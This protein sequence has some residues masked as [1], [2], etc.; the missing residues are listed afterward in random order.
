[1]IKKNV[2]IA[3]LLLVGLLPACAVVEND[4][5]AWSHITLNKD[6]E[7]N[8]RWQLI[9]SQR[10]G[11]QLDDFRVNLLR[12]GI[13]YN[14][15]GS[16]KNISLWLG[17]DWFTYYGGESLEQENRIWQQILY[18]N[19]CRK[20][21]LTSRTRLEE[22]IFE[23]EDMLTRLRQQLRADYKLTEKFRLIAGGE[24]FVNLNSNERVDEV[25]DQNRMNVGLG[26]DF[27][28]NYSLDM[29]YMLQH[30]NRDIDSLNHTFVTNLILNF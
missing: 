7:N 22:R 3:A 29:L 10:F 11:D 5:Y 18:I 13:G 24:I 6:F 23:H 2:T 8:F 21:R 15:P 14:L 25:L 26:Y 28:K 1:M 16:Y 12:N 27:T 30:N 20:W 9:T 17:H 4:L 19:D